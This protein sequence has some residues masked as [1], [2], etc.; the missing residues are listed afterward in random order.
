MADSKRLNSLHDM[1]QFWTVWT[2]DVILRGNVDNML[3]KCQGAGP[4]GLPNCPHLSLARHV[5][6][7]GGLQTCR[8]IA[9]CSG[10]DLPLLPGVKSYRWICIKKRQRSQ[11]SS[12]KTV[13]AGAGWRLSVTPGPVCTAAKLPFTMVEKVAV[14]LNTMEGWSARVEITLL[15]IVAI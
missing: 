9:S 2:S 14:I 13:Y 4:A 3:E 10:E 15:H 6:S 1:E 8:G 5:S 12:E 7:S 11:A